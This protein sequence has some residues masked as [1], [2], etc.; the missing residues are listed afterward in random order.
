MSREAL[1]AELG[2]EAEPFTDLLE[3]MEGISVDGAKVA[4]A[5]HAVGLTPDQQRE[6]DRVIELITEAGF[7]PPLTQEPIHIATRMATTFLRA[8]ARSLMAGPV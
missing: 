2:L 6:R 5:G 7:Q 8:K 4:L 1:R 3:G